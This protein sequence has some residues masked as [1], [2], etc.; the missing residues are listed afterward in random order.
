MAA[1]STGD[2]AKA[3]A[4][5]PFPIIANLV[6]LIVLGEGKNFLTTKDT[7]FFQEGHEAVLCLSCLLSVLHGFCLYFDS[8]FFLGTT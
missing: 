1:I 7:K 8:M 5:L 2:F 4:Q 3:V 6:L